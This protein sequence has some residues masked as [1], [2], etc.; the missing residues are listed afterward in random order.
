M[1]IR[2]VR[3][4]IRCRSNYHFYG[5][6]NR[7]NA[8]SVSPAKLCTHVVQTRPR[9]CATSHFQVTSKARCTSQSCCRLIL[10]HFISF[11][12][13][14]RE[15][16]RGNSVEI[17]NVPRCR[18]RAFSSCLLSALILINFDLFG[19]FVLIRSRPQ[20][21]PG[22]IRDPFTGG[23]HSRRWSVRSNTTN[24]SRGFSRSRAQ[25]GR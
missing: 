23:I 19:H 9:C 18:S 3:P 2:D 14:V 25:N 24:L 7:E 20:Q 11:Y 1:I 5:G 12:F 17:F 22:N 13:I 8:C 4:G 10:F 6:A 15:N 16:K 21:H